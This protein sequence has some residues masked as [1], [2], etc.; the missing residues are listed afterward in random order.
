MR[1]LS[2]QISKIFLLTV[3]ILSGSLMTFAVDLSQYRQNIN[4]LRRDLEPL[5]YSQEEKTPTESKNLEKRIIEKI[6]REYRLKEKV[7]WKG[8]TFEID[9][10]WITA[11]L[12]KFQESQEENRID[13]IISLDSKLS[14]LEYKLSELEK[15]SEGGLTKDQNKQKLSEILSKADYYKPPKKEEEQNPVVKWLEEVIE[16]FSKWLR[17]LF[18][19]VSPSDSTTN[20]QG[21]SSLLQIIII[22]VV[23][24]FIIFLI[25]RYAPDLVKRFREKEKDVK[26]ARVILGEKIMADE[27]ATN[28]F[29]EAEKL[30]QAG[31]LRAAIRKGYIAVLC[32][33]SDRK[34]IGLAQHK[35]NRDYLRDVRKNRDVYQN[36]T[37][38]TGSFEHTWYGL[39]KAEETDWTS[40]KEKYQQTV[41][42]ARKK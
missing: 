40:F 4:Q 25:Y 17:S 7:E 6:E 29:A 37:S 36:M 34:L 5:Y 12:G 38:M 13:I 31:D 23:A 14:A 21:L 41:E 24:L 30:A 42:K 22:A 33:L 9:N 27:D 18:P 32:E 3:L 19:E 2:Y 10:S 28:L 11:D 1:Q 39:A 16:A 15:A 8:D 20:Y 26:T 35:T